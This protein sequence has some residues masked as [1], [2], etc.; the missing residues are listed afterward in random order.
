MDEIYPKKYEVVE[1][2]IISCYKVIRQI[3]LYC[4]SALIITRFFS[5]ALS[6]AL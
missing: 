5:S 6:D 1:V 2:L 4:A 3:I